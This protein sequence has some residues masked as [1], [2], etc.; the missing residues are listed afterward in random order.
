[1][2]RS[3]KDKETIGT[4][5]TGD[6]N[7]L[8]EVI[9]NALEMELHVSTS[10]VLELV[11][12]K[13]R[14]SKDMTLRLSSFCKIVL[15][16]HRACGYGKA[17]AET[18]TI[19][20]AGGAVATPL[21][22]TLG[23]HKLHTR[24]VN[25]HPAPVLGSEEL[26]VADLTDPAS[27]DH[28]VE[29]ATVTYVTVG[30]P[31]KAAVWEQLWP[32]FMRSVIE[33]CKKHRS[34]LVFFDNVYLYRPDSVSHMTEENPIGPTSRKG[35]VREVIYRLLEAEM[36]QGTLPVAVARAADFAYATYG[37][38]DVMLWDSLRKGKAAQWLGRTD[39]IH[40]FTY[41]PDAGRATAF[42]GITRNAFGQV[43]HVPTDQ[44]PRTIKDW[45]VLLADALGTKPRVSAIPK[46]A[47]RALGLFVPILREFGEMMYQYEQDYVFDSTK[48]ERF[49]GISPTSGADVAEAVAAKEA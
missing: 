25:R 49:F 37:I 9:G 48:F 31:Y 32:P 30:F 14:L 17:M 7:T 8:F 27:V 10:T 38:L 23:E 5:S 26:I 2:I 16:L 13:R 45:T 33:A 39:K 20:G 21:A 24:L 35:T 4:D 40:T 12:G 1:M 18:H 28:A 46:P 44:T 43:W 15:A 22:K 6:R 11:H 3:F 36:K 29:G 41:T 19:L 34:K 42:I 47:V